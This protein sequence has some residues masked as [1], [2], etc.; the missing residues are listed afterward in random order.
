MKKRTAAAKFAMSVVLMA[1]MMLFTGM[2]TT[3]EAGAAA[4]MTKAGFLKTVISQVKGQK[5]AAGKKITVTVSS[6]GSVK[7]MGKTYSKSAVNEYRKKYGGTSSQ[8]QYVTAAAKL[9][10]IDEETF[11]GASKN[12]TYG[13]AMAILERAYELLSKDKL[14]T[15]DVEFVKN[16][17]IYDLDMAA[18]SERTLIAKAYMRGFYAGKSNGNFTKLRTLGCEKAATKTSLTAMAKRLTSGED[19]YKF[20]EDWQ[21]LRISKK[22][23]PKQAKYF[24]YILDDFTN[25]YY[26]T[27]FEFMQKTIDGY[28]G[29]EF[30]K[31]FGNAKMDTQISSWDNL[32]KKP[33]YSSRSKWIIDYLNWCQSGT[34][35]GFSS[36]LDDLKRHCQYIFPSEMEKFSKLMREHE[37]EFP[38]AAGGYALKEGEARM[39][40]EAAEAY[41]RTI[42]NVDYRTIEEAS[43][44]SI[45]GVRFSD[46]YI[47]DCILNETVIEC[48]RVAAD[49]G[50]VS[51]QVNYANNRMVGYS[52]RVYVHYRVTNDNGKGDAALVYNAQE[53]GDEYPTS[54]REVKVSKDGLRFEWA[55]NDG[56]WRDGYFDVFFP[57]GYYGFICTEYDLTRTRNFYT[58]LLGGPK[59]CVYGAPGRLT[60]EGVFVNDNVI[61]DDDTQDVIDR[62]RK[63]WKEDY[64]KYVPRSY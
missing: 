49:P 40:A 60:A 43:G 38:N 35:G 34:K 59:Q 56:K 57:G 62:L 2:M 27:E 13:E 31:E 17:R 45:D 42:F 64:G 28:Y 41:T 50:S 52:V 5:N 51:Y 26:D 32:F 11:T 7:V 55:G 36:M 4:K 54:L 48:D 23:L 18:E 37:A 10:L 1:V 9:G 44:R 24:P 3:A 19:R 63:R 6:K 58:E 12:I 22:N 21:M 14:K 29:A 61:T 39:M 33:S 25:E 53:Y 8:A 46:E 47:R 15:D 16:N 20:S 30:G